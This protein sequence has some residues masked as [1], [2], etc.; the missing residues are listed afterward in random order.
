MV[1][2]IDPD[3][4]EEAGANAPAVIG[5]ACRP[6]AAN[7]RLRQLILDLK[8]SKE[9]TI[10][11]ISQDEVLE[12]GYS[13][14]AKERAKGLVESFE[15]FITDSKDE[16]SALQVLYS[17]PYRRRLRYDDIKALAS[18]IHAPPRQW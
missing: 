1:R 12:A 16:L 2:A 7:P 10:D 5:E 15:Q 17:R 14:S 11:V 9:Q 8:K 13:A 6:L 4:L 18:A 3:V